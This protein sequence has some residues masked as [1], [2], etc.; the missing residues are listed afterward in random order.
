MITKTL[1]W[2]AAILFAAGMAAIGPAAAE[3]PAATFDSVVSVLPE[4]PS[5]AQR[6]EEPEGSGV[7]LYG[8]G[9]VVTMNH[10]LGP[11]TKVRLRR[12]DGTIL[13]AEIV[14]RDTASDLA[15]LKAGKDLAP[16]PRGPAPGLA[17]RACAIGNQFGLGLSVTCGV[18]SATGKSGLGFASMEDHIQTDATINPGS[19]GGALVD[20]DGR[21]IGVIAAIFTKGRDGNL[22]VNF[23]AS[24]PFVLRVTDDLK[25]HGKVLRGYAGMQVRNPR[26]ANGLAWPGVLVTKVDPDG[27]A[28]KAGA[29]EGDVLQAVDGRP[30]RKARGAFA[31]IH[32]KRAGEAVR[33]AI[34]RAGKTVEIDMTLAK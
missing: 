27:P 13:S 14:G 5:D 25:A 12:A 33:L 29:R 4:W 15:L 11:A 19:S 10:V 31:A 22:G 26:P 2:S 30:V 18:V 3:I 28:A 7:V 8:G 34:F 6:R 17:Q 24:L 23:A 21:L 1:I 20:G 9:Y 32:M 16:I